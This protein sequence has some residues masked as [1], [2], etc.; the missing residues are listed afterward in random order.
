MYDFLY[1]KMYTCHDDNMMRLLQNKFHSIQINEK[2][3][4][5]FLNNLCNV[6]VN[7]HKHK[8]NVK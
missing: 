8:Q 6:I 5:F 3:N 2:Q 1:K 7:C 4:Y